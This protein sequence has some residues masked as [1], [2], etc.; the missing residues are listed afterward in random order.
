MAKSITLST[1]HDRLPFG[2]GVKVAPTLSLVAQAKN[3]LTRLP[4]PK[5]IINPLKLRPQEFS[6]GLRAAIRWVELETNFQLEPEVNISGYALAAILSG[7]IHNPSDVSALRLYQRELVTDLAGARGWLLRFLQIAEGLRPDN[8]FDE[9]NEPASFFVRGPKRVLRLGF[10]EDSPFAQAAFPGFDLASGELYY[11]RPVPDNLVGLQFRVQTPGGT[12]VRK[13][14]YDRA[15]AERFSVY[16]YRAEERRQARIL[17]RVVLTDK[18]LLSADPA[19][20]IPVSPSI[21]DPS[22]KS[23]TSI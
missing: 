10:R 6:R 14:A 11:V 1:I 22:S 7:E 2:Y 17:N 8:A 5:K 15:L 12:L 19:Q 18:T 9:N 4:G 21:A 23:I 16:T 3:I 20:A 13:Y